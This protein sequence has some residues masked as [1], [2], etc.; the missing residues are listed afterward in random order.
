MNAL[1]IQL[2]EAYRKEF[3]S[4]IDGGGDAFHQEVK[5]YKEISRLLT[6]RG[7]QILETHEI[8]KIIDSYVKEKI[9][10]GCSEEAV[11]VL[12]RLNSKPYVSKEQ[13]QNYLKFV[14]PIARPEVFDGEVEKFIKC[15]PPN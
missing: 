5:F 15:F 3:L 2:Y 9:K 14:K 7:K 11:E 1:D 8:N 6:I 10:S 12:R 13:F 4:K